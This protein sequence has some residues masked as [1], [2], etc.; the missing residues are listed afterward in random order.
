M[1]PPDAPAASDD[2][3][4]ATDPSAAALERDTKRMEDTVQSRSCEN[5]HRRDDAE[6]RQSS[7]EAAFADH[8]Q[9]IRHARDEQRHHRQRDDRLNASQL[10]A[11]R[12][13]QESWRPVT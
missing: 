4:R 10:S 6:N 8:H 13:A 9:E 5:C 3:A 12:A 1:T 2:N 7:P 11:L